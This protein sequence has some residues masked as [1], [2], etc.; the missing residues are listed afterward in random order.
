MGTGH[1]HLA[2]HSKST[3]PLPGAVRATLARGQTWR[4]WKGQVRLRG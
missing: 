2:G 3:T 4:P 1:Q